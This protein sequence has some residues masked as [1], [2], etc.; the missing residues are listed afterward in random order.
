[1]KT[2]FE[3]NCWLVFIFLVGLISGVFLL[4]IILGI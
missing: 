1:M 4:A 3:L 2:E